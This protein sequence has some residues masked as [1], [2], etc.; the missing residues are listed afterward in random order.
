MA[1]AQDFQ[2]SLGYTVREQ[3]GVGRWGTDQVSFQGLRGLC[4]SR[5]P[6]LSE[7]SS[8][9]GT[10]LWA[11]INSMSPPH[12]LLSRY[13]LVQQQAFKPWGGF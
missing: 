5:L 12:K 7:W 2:A 11:R 9:L 1:G 10:G 6:C 3:V 4:L 8:R 13:N